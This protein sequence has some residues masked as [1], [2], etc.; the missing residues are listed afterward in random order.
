MKNFKKVLSLVLAVLMVVG[1]LVIAPTEAKAADTYTKIT[2]LS[3]ITSGGNY[4]I[5]GANGDETYALGTTIANKIDGVKV[6]VSGD[7]ISGTEIP[8]WKITASGENY[9]LNNGTDDLA[10]NS[11]TNLKKADDTSADKAEWKIEAREGGLFTITNVN[12]TSRGLAFRHTSNGSAYNKF[13]PYAT[14]N[15]TFTGGTGTDYVFGFSIY[16]T[17]AQQEVKENITLPAGA[18]QADIVNAAY[19]AMTDGVELTGT[20]ALTG[21]I[22]SIDTAYNEQYS[23]S[24]V[25]IIVGELS[26][27]PIQCYRVKGAEG[28]DISG[29]AVG[30]TIK[31]EGTLSYYNTKVQ[32]ST[33]A[34]VKTIEKGEIPDTLPQTA[35]ATEIVNKA[36]ELAAANKPMIGTYTL[37]GVIKSVDTKY[38]EQYGNITVTIQVGDLADKAFQCYRLKGAEGVDISGLKVNDTIKVQGTFGSYNGKPQYAQG[39]EVL[40]ITPGQAEED[41]TTPSDTQKPSG[42]TTTT[43]AKP[44]YEQKY[45]S[46]ILA[47]NFGDL[48]ASGDLKNCNI[49]GNWDVETKANN[50]K[51]LG[52][53]VYQFILTFD[54]TEKD[55]VLEYKVAFNNAWTDNIGEKSV[56][57]D[58]AA[59]GGNI[60]LT[61]PA[62]STSVTFIVSEK[63]TVVY[64]NITNAAKV[65]EYI[66]ISK[67]GDTTNY[68][69][70]FM[71]VLAGAGLVVA[72]VVGKKKMA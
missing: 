13:G 18:T 11:S 26:D 28:V 55:I 50:M 25:T 53:G 4:V 38:S 40:S 5:I 71:L 6:T 15:D 51:Y 12:S 31:V 56:N 58:F 67:M 33:G 16:K 37:T 62:G 3:E 32:F 49:T 41:T 69:L 64:D 9:K 61:I 42:G 39:A 68:A 7:S 29:L 66:K 10:Y 17:T 27:K 72:S 43:P 24:T 48:I 1:G 22:T 60:K 47:G 70:Y 21:V 35:T 46:A 23:N 54:K 2:S 57:T 59:N 44:K 63:D 34:E 8:V 36:W 14:S 52:N 45:D 20:H 19:Q 65:N 30:D